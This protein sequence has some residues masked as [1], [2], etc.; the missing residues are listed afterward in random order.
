MDTSERNQLIL[1]L[2]RNGASLQQIADRTGISAQRVCRIVQTRGAVD[3]EADRDGRGQGLPCPECSGHSRTIRTFR[4]TK[5]G[6]KRRHLCLSCGHRW[7]SNQ[8]NIPERTKLS[9]ATDGIAHR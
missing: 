3:D 5:D 2:R 7:N 9:I 4:P 8:V 6:R 1:E